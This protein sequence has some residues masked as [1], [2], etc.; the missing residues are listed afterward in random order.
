MTQK[1]QEYDVSIPRLPLP[2]AISC[3]SF[4]PCGLGEVD[5]FGV[6]ISAENLTHALAKN[7]DT[8]IDELREMLSFNE[9]LR[10][11]K[12]RFQTSGVLDEALHTYHII[13]GL[14]KPTVLPPWEKVD[15]T[16]NYLTIT[17]VNPY[18][19]FEMVGVRHYICF[20]HHNR[21]LH[22]AQSSLENLV[23]REVQRG[24]ASG[25]EKAVTQQVRT[26]EQVQSEREHLEAQLA[27]LKATEA[28]M[29]AAECRQ[30]QR[31]ELKRQQE[32]EKQAK[33]QQRST[34]GYVYVVKGERGAYKIGRTSKPEDRIKTFS[35]KLPFPV[36]FEVL[37]QTPDMYSLESE[38]HDHYSKQ[39][40]HLDCKRQDMI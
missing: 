32:A 4:L 35:V 19:E 11:G 31:E 25:V 33:R 38:L 15:G 36:E 1:Q 22:E 3:F 5:Y 18:R 14:R 23:R 10:A 17:A 6:R 21:L 34:V 26:L 20:E 27:E 9:M 39:G 16:D 28:R 2:Y 13:R 8:L 29:I 30:Q 24:I 12:T 37:I 40:K 7:P